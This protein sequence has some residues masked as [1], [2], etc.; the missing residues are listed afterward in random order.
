MTFIT[1]FKWK[2][3]MKV[4]ELLDNYQT[5]VYQ[6]IE[7]KKASEVFVKMKKDNTKIFLT[8]TS[9]MVTSGLRGFFAQI[10]ALKMADVIVT[11]VGGIEEDIMK[12]K[13]ERFSVGDFNSDDVDLHEKTCG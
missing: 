1:D 13:G 4:K 9:N 3:G 6:S 12:A 2:K 11:T 8:F 10:I 7:L 5:L